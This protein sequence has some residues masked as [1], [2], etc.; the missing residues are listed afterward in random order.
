MFSNGSKSLKDE[1]IQ[2]KL[3]IYMYVYKY[4]KRHVYRKRILNFYVRA[5]YI[6]GS[7]EMPQL[8]NLH[9]IM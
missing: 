9:I 2:F 4:G 5:K 1:L 3:Y 7:S 6:F 8:T